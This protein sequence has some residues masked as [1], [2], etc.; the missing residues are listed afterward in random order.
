MYWR[1]AAAGAL[2]A[3]LVVGGT[4]VGM[5]KQD[6]TASV[7]ARATLPDGSVAALLMRLA[8]A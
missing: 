6:E 8:T 4:T 3:G 7:E 5:P 1:S 2:I